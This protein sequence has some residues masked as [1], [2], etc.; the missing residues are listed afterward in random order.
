MILLCL[1]M[2]KWIPVHQRWGPRGCASLSINPKRQLAQNACI[3]RAGRHPRNG[4]C[5]E[6]VTESDTDLSALIITCYLE[7]LVTR[8]TQITVAETKLMPNI[9]MCHFL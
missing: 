1:G 7:F 4:P 2:W 8:V 3:L 5:L 6:E 9:G